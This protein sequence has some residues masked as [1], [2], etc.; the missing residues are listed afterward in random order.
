MKWTDS[1]SQS[2]HVSNLR[3]FA[4]NYDWSG[5]KFPVS[6]KEIGVFETEN[7]ISVDVLVTEGKDIYIC[8][9]TN[10][11]CNREICF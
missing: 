4:D 7:D 2:E 6:I 9:K 5:L 8:R 11:Q 1:K 10:C 3:K